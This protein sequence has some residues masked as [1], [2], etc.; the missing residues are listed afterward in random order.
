MLPITLRDAGDAWV[1]QQRTSA[2]NP[3]QIDTFAR[4]FVPREEQTASGSWV[5]RLWINKQ[6]GLLRRAEVVQIGAQ[7]REKVLSVLHMSAWHVEPLVAGADLPMPPVP[8]DTVAYT[9]GDFG[10]TV[11][12]D[13]EPFMPPQR[14]WVWRD[15]FEVVY[16]SDGRE[17][18]AEITDPRYQEQQRQR[19][20]AALLNTNLDHLEIVGLIHG[21]V[22]RVPGST[23]TIVVRQGTAPLLRYVLR[24]ESLGYDGSPGWNQS[25]AVPVFLGGQERTAW[26]L[27]DTNDMALV[28]EI[29]DVIV[30]IS[31]WD[32][33]YIE[34]ALLDA[35]PQLE[36]VDAAQWKGEG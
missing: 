17:P 8:P 2:A 27:E 11:T 32:K 19:F 36:S 7:D 16:R 13:L 33:A 23:R 9:Y 14:E 26:L 20:A 35:L 3:Y 15:G 1:L 10:P 21:T 25:R 18:L 22:Y 34:G 12:S 5:E 6:A 30:H 24:Y 29:D 28:V 31:G 4:R